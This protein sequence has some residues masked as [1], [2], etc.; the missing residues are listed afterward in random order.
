MTDPKASDPS[1][2]GE[3]PVIFRDKR[4]DDPETGEVRESETDSAATE[5]DA[6]LTQLAAQLAERTTD[7]QRV[8]AEYANYRKRVDRDRDAL[9]SNAKA[10][11]VTE[12]LVVL[13]DLELAK[14][15]GDLTGAFK[16]VADRL[17]STL[18]RLGL[19][20]FGELGDEFDP[21]HHEAVQF[22][23]SPDVTSQVISLVMRRGFSFK[24]KLIRAAVVGVTGPEHEV[25]PSSDDVVRAAE[26]ILEAEL[27][28]DD[29]DRADDAAARAEQGDNAA[30]GITAEAD[31]SNEK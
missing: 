4:K 18:E 14:S 6:E 15:H 23:T 7:L 5:T 13:D 19:Q 26:E 28:A 27:V 25:S 2:Q 8:S 20:A 16:A 30:P 9:V 17:T 1:T 12:L 29:A 31:E 10:A 24:E 22:G 21:S 11:V 3:E